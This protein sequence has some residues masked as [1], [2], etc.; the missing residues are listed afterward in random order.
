MEL[1][2]PILVFNVKNA[3]SELKRMNELLFKELLKSHGDNLYTHFDDKCKEQILAV[4]N[5]PSPPTLGTPPPA[6]PQPVL[7]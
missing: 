6:P 2:Q 7:E 5:M 3:N 1:V 4:L